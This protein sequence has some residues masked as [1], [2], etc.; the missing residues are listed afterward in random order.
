[1]SRHRI[2]N[3]PE[4]FRTGIKTSNL[5]RKENESGGLAVTNCMSLYLPETDGED[6]LFVAR[7]GCDDG[8]D[9]C[10][11]FGFGDPDIPVSEEGAVEEARN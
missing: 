8:F 11:V 1:M 7:I 2:E 3:L 5:W 6:G 9:I 4:P 10:D